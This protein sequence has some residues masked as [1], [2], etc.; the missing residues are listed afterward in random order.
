MKKR[1]KILIVD[2][3][4]K[5]LASL[6]SILENYGFNTLTTQD[7]FEAI[8]IVEKDDIDL[9]IL[10]LVMPSID[11][12]SVL[13]KILEKKPSL[14]VIMLSGHGT[15]PKAVEATKIGAFD[16]LE[17]PVEIEKIIIT[18]ENALSKSRL[19]REK[20][21]LIQDALERY[22][23]I[24]ISKRMQ[25]IFNKIERVASD[26]SKVLIIGESGTGK[27][28]IA[29][30]IHLRS[31]RAGG[32]FQVVNC[33]AIPE[34]LIE[35]EL[36]GHEKGAFTG[37]LERKIGK[38][39]LAN[40][41]TLFLDEIGDMSLR[42]QAKVLRAIETEEIERIGGKEKIK[43]DTRIICASNK[44]LREAVKKGTFREDLYFRIN[45]IP[46]HVPPL[47]E[48]KEDIPALLDYYTKIF[49]EE[50]KRPLIK[51]HPSALGILLEY[52][53]YGN[54]RELRNLVEKVVVLS[55]SDIVTRE[56]IEKYLK[57]SKIEE[58]VDKEDYYKSL[59]DA[60][61]KAERE[62]ILTKLILNSWDYE[63]TAEE[64]GISR[65]TLF[66]KMKKYGIKRG[67]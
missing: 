7:G 50:R 62:L 25:E 36:F 40:K 65:A 54:V 56:E 1:E 5:I 23:M 24:G 64:L 38:F 19:E 47:R 4:I 33:A 27:E 31:N 51:F 17:K 42:L 35:S 63:K 6:S 3:D 9:V 32:P 8:Q 53:W 29:R 14:P 44:D 66:N 34:E 61:E 52:P 10:D 48:R 2:D 28:L 55:K 67:E 18:I 16:F 41:G 49:C 43:I 59:E 37:A 46:I 22:K 26:D 12:I 58:N 57:E 15:I 39:E 60:R 21:T 11:G 30:A 45:V 20:Q 13:G